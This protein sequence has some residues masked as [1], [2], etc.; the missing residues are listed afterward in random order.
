MLKFAGW[1]VA[2]LRKKKHLT[3]TEL[4]ALLHKHGHGTTQ[5]QVSRW[6]GGQRP[7]K[8]IIT[9]LCQ[10][11]GCRPDDLF[12]EDAADTP[13]FRAAGQERDMLRDLLRNALELVDATGDRVSS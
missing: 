6:E 9:A 12:E 13:P 5:T 10:E 4:A 11:L 8:Y 1:K 2:E 7:R 3:Q